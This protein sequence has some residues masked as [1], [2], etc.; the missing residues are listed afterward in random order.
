MLKYFVG[1]F[2]YN[3]GIQDYFIEV[4]LEY[5]IRYFW[6]LPTWFMK[7]GCVSVPI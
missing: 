5:Y 6:H 4:V 1:L 2:R 3:V 7:V